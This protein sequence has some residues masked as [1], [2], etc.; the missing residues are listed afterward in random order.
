MTAVFVHG[1]PETA[2][3]WD[4]LVAALERDDTVQLALPAFGNPLPDGFEPTMHRYAEWLAAELER[5]DEVDL[6][7][8]D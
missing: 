5:F 7:G 6:V 2:A 1:V 4:P 3:L 8:H